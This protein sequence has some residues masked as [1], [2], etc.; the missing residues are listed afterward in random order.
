MKLAS[1]S[2]GGRASYGIV[3]DGGIVD[4]GKLIGAQYPDLKALLTAGPALLNQL[5]AQTSTIP[6]DEVTFLPVIPNP[7][8]IFCAGLNYRSH[9]EET[10]RTASEKPVIF[11]RLAA[12]QVG[13]GQPMICPAI[14]DQFDYEGELAIVIGKPGRHIS[15]DNALD[16]IAGYSCYN[17]GSLRDWQ[18]HTSQWTPGKNFA[19]TGAFGPWLVTADE[20]PDPTVLSLATRLNGQ[21]VQSATVDL[22][23]FSIPELIEY[24][25]VWS[26][27]IPGDV[28]VTGTPGG[29]GFKRNPP[30]LMKAGD[31]VEVEISNIGTLSNPIEL[32]RN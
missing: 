30:L 15:R 24:V 28:I 22:L 6:I 12:S 14:S 5:R 23:I 4:L 16:H 25:S 9:V 3:K 1:F 29:V 10:G 13:H 2:H 19:A 27:L 32:E 18:R 26:E 11:L 7:D 8:K 21:T 20:I 31:T 17:D